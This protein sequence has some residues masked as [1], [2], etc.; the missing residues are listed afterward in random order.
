MNTKYKPQ[1]STQ[2]SESGDVVIL[3]EDGDIIDS[4]SLRSFELLCLEQ[5]LTKTKSTRQKKWLE[6]IRQELEEHPES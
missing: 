5:G 3:R 4:L 6:A 2:Y 1:Y